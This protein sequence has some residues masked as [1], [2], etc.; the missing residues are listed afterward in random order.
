M[1]TGSLSLPLVEQ[2]DRCLEPMSSCDDGGPQDGVMAFHVLGFH[3]LEEIGKRRPQ[4]EKIEKMA[5][6]ASGSAM[7]SGTSAA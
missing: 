5:S 6:M 7:T 1:R 3:R 2:E 4:A